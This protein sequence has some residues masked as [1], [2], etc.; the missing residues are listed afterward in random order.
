LNRHY[1]KISPC[2]SFPKRGAPFPLE[3]GGQVRQELSKREVREKIFRHNKT[4][5]KGGI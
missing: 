1:K 5:R 3:K 4:S 2:P